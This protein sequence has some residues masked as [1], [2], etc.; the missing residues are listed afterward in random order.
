[1]KNYKIYCQFL[2]ESALNVR[3]LSIVVPTKQCVNSCKF[4]VSKLH[5][6]DYPDLSREDTFEEKYFNILERLST[7]GAHI[8]ILTGEGEPLQNKRFLEIF[9]R[10]NK[11]LK[12]PLY[13]ELQS[14]GVMLSD[15]NLK[16]LKETVG[17]NLIS[18]SVTDLMNDKN[19]MNI[20]GVHPKLSFNLADI[21]KRIKAAGLML[22][23]SLNLIKVYDNY[24]LEDMFDHMKSNGIDQ[25][26]FR[27]L[28]SEGECEID[29]WIKQNSVSKEFINKMYDY[30]KNNGKILGTMPTRYSVKGMS[31][32]I[33]DDCMGRKEIQQMRYL[34]IRPDGNI[35]TKWDS[36]EKFIIK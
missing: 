15:E 34:I 29:K 19:N 5:P 24:D 20:I 28:F 13:I 23:Y 10:L 33:D 4:C 17:A 8:A 18:L 25:V 36:T 3:S 35:Y 6:H 12:E 11:Q 9:G 14:S 27:I 16:F 2:Y 21:S 1:M 31:V 32:C 30:V 7:A 26:T 22:R